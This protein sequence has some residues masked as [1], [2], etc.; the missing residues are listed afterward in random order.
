MPLTKI[1]P[2]F[3]QACVPEK[4]HQTLRIPDPAALCQ[5]RQLLRAS[6]IAALRPVHANR[7]QQVSP[8]RVSLPVLLRLLPKKVILLAHAHTQLLSFS[9]YKS[10]KKTTIL[11]KV[12]RLQSVR[13][14]RVN[15]QRLHANLRLAIHRVSRQE[16]L[17]HP[18]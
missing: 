18:V 2:I 4:L 13:H 5:I 16:A 10:N 8:L 15:R 11:L 7:A 12:K 1:S 9:C 3:S 14:F 17:V 6:F